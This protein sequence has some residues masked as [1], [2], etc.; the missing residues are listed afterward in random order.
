MGLRIVPMT[1]SA[2][3]D[4]IST[5]HRHHKK[6]QGHR[7]SLGVK[8]ADG[9][10]VGVATC[11]RPV[12]RKTDQ[13]SVLEVTRLATDGTYNACSVLYGACARVAKEMGFSRI[14]TFILDSEPG[15]SLKA[16][17]WVK[18]GETGGASWDVPSRPRED[19][20]VLAPRSRWV[21]I[22]NKE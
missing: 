7:F 14:Q 1:L 2:V 17:G 18:D 15:T 4:F 11:G 5:H 19:K 9:K 10:L 22:L 12:A 8:D 6:V 21:R 16:S 20:C 13:Y 3:N